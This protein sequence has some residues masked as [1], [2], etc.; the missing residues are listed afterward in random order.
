MLGLIES[1]TV[2]YVNSN[3]QH[4]AAIVVRVQDKEQGVVNIQVFEDMNGVSYHSGVEYS[5]EH[6]PE[7][8]HW[9]EEEVASE[10]IAPTPD[11]TPEPIV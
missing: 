7:T 10:V 11:V 3:G 4:M 9:V 8:W 5:N 2:H 1:K 6:S